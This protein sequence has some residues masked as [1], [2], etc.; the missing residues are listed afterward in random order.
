MRRW[1]TDLLL[2]VHVSFQPI[3]VLDGPIARLVVE[4]YFMLGF[5]VDELHDAML[6]ERQPIKIQHSEFHSYENLGSAGTLV[7][8]CVFNQRDVGNSQMQ[9]KPGKIARIC[10]KCLVW[11]EKVAKKNTH[12]DLSIVKNEYSHIST[13]FWLRTKSMPTPA[14][15]H[16]R[17]DTQTYRTCTEKMTIRNI[18]HT[19][20]FP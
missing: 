6:K 17:T 10:K 20:T 11:G 4:N 7:G 2:I 12:A 19:T 18:S 16:K 13:S 14:C 9:L 15:T 5:V 8:M 3:E 1:E